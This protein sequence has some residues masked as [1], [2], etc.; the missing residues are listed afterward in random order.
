MFNK[1]DY[2]LGVLDSFA[3]IAELFPG[4][5]VPAALADK[6]LKV[7]QAAVRAHEAATG[8]PLD[9]SLLQP[10]QPMPVATQESQEPQASQEPKQ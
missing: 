7:T 9:L 8:Q 6:L 5:T 2:I 10:I 3:G 1:L 4:T